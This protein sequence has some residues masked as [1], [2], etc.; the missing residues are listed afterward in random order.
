MIGNPAHPPE[1]TISS[2]SR[3]APDEVSA[4]ETSLFC[5]QA[6][7]GHQAPADRPAN[8]PVNCLCRLEPTRAQLHKFRS[9]FH[10]RFPRSF[11]RQSPLIF[12]GEFVERLKRGR[13][14]RC[15]SWQIAKTS[16]A[17]HSTKNTVMKLISPVLSS[18]QYSRIPV[19][20]K[21]QQ[22]LQDPPVRACY[23]SRRTRA[24]VA[25]AVSL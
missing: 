4:D 19:S 23:S 14:R 12:A 15:F 8:A 10:V 24:R 13:K 2:S 7:D 21:D 5:A 3:G 11:L 20:R 17:R 25:E 9:D 6:I 16:F 1:K 22:S 18:F